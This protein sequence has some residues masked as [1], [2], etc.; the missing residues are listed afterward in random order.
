[1][2]NTDDIQI[3][4]FCARAPALRVA[5]V[6]ETFPPE[7]NGV[8]MTLGRIVDGL[9]QRGHEVQ[10][11]RPR[12]GREDD[13]ERRPG[14]EQVLSHGVPIPRYPDLHFGLPSGS[15]LFKLWQKH[16]PDV[17]HVATEGPLG[18]SAVT[19][20]RKLQIPV[21]SS[22]HTNF[23]H[24]TQHYGIGLLKNSID[25]YLRKMHNRTQATLVPTPAL[26]QALE[27]RGYKNVSVMSRGVAIEQFKPECRSAALRASWGVAP[28]ALAVLHVGRLAKEKNVSTLLAAFAAIQV[29]RPDARLV[30]VGDGPLRKSLQETCPNAVFCGVRGG[31]DLAAHYASGDLFL[32]PSLSETYGNVVPEAMASGLAVLSY[33]RAAAGSL[34]RH[35]VSGELIA[36]EDEMGFIQAAVALACDAPRMQTLRSQAPQS[37]AHLGWAAVYDGFIATLR[38]VINAH[39]AHPDEI[40]TRQAVAFSQPS[41]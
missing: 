4:S 8:A 5:L 24:Y 32:F 18:W 17:V 7:V 41:A 40:R 36:C 35:G 2:R 39:D 26:V 14:L 29:Q 13:A 23:D 1:M 9:L 30:F 10:V 11:V 15:R 28:D 38:G 6:T 3:E 34:I 37:V 12:Q 22:F 20:A 31:A 33:D 21:T 25:A 19:A 16:R 27:S